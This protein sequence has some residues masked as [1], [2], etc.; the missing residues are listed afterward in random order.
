MESIG[1]TTE[2]E[3]KVAAEEYVG[4]AEKVGEEKGAEAAAKL[5]EKM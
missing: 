5:L 4:K 2:A 3:A 1:L